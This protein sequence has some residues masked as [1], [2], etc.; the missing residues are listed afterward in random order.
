MNFNV[1]PE[2]LFHLNKEIKAV[3]IGDKLGL[4]IID[5]GMTKL[6]SL[7]NENVDIPD[8]SDSGDDEMIED[9]QDLSLLENTPSKSPAAKK[10]R[11]STPYKTNPSLNSTPE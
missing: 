3:D 4:E 1:I 11:T 2:T 7:E 9:L 6:E 5:S 10:M 8:T